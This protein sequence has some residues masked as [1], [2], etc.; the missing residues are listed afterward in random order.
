MT[1]RLPETSFEHDEIIRKVAENLEQKGYQDIRAAHQ[2]GSEWPVPEEVFAADGSRRM[3]PDLTARRGDSSFYF[4]I[5]TID[6]ITSRQTCVEV[7]ILS[8]LARSRENHFFF[9]IVPESCK[10]LSL[11]ILRKLNVAPGG[12]TFVLH[13]TQEGPQPSST[14][15]GYS[16]PL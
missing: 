3:R 1:F 16:A 8:E 7:E 9:L 2:S 5:E 14:D 6:S 10:H 11:F 15:Y 12:R 13:M 4:E